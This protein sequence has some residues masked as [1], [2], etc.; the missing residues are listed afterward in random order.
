MFRL[1]FYPCIDL[2]NKSQFVFEHKK[3]SA[4]LDVKNAIAD[5]T[6][7]LHGDG[8]MKD[9]SSMAVVEHFEDDEWI[10]LDEDDISDLLAEESF[11]G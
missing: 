1:N 4:V 10:E 6:L 3:L 8:F 11:N 2:P 7:M 9:Y 5:Y